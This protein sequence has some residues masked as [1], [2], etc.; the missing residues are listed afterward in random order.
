MGP[1]SSRT[2]R[3]SNETETL[4][5]DSAR[6]RE[7][8]LEQDYGPAMKLGVGASGNKNLIIFEYPK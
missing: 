4:S 1:F 7:C 2:L 5:H 3:F 6:H 8:P